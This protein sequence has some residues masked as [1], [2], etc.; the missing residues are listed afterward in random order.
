MDALKLI[1]S[2]HERLADLLEEAMDANEPAERADLLHQMRAELM[3]H[4]RMEETI[5]YP[6]LRTNAKAKDIVLE[7]YEEHHVI[8][9]IL[10]ELLDVPEELDEWKAKLKVL[11]ENIEHHIEEEEGEMFKIAKKVFDEQTLEELGAKMQAA[12]E[13][14]T[15]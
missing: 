1:K 9:M 11:K 15:A 3:A 8:D 12:K 14:S 10:D 7:G 5:F 13:A 4:E 6:A 2:D